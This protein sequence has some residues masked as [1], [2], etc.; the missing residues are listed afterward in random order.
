M[1]EQDIGWRNGCADQDLGLENGQMWLRFA[2][3]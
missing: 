1:D 2:Q 3:S